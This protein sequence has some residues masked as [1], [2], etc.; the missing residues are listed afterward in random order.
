MVK[1]ADNN[2]AQTPQ[3]RRRKR[4]EKRCLVKFCIALVVFL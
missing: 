1:K 2:E 4:V 3:G